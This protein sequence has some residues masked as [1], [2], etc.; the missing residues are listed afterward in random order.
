MDFVTP[1]TRCADAHQH[2]RD[3]SNSASRNAEIG[4]LKDRSER[5]H[6]AHKTAIDCGSAPGAK[7]TIPHP[8]PHRV[9]RVCDR[10]GGTGG[11]CEIEIPPVVHHRIV[12]HNLCLIQHQS[13]ARH[14]HFQISVASGVNR[15]ENSAASAPLQLHLPNVLHQ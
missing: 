6:H 2:S 8:P 9:A 11:G 7:F 1:L 12:N 14:A 15:P 10:F 5:A 13:I 3:S 4:V